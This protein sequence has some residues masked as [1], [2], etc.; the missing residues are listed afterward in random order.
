MSIT[1]RRRSYEVLEGEL[2]PTVDGVTEV[3]RPGVAIVPSNARHSVRPGA[4][5]W[6]AGHLVDSSKWAE[7]G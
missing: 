6:A 5:R 2:E 1:I 4:D 3:A 7:F